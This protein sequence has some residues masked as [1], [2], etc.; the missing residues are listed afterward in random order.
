MAQHETSTCNEDVIEVVEVNGATAWY[1]NGNLHRTDGPAVDYHDGTQLWYQNGDLHREDGP[2]HIDKDGSQF[3]Y[4]HGA[5]HR[6]DG[7]AVISS[8]GSQSWYLDDK[9]VDPL[10]HFMRRKLT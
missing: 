2:A 8:N 5:I 9:E 10:V 6:E 3:W 1:R 7:P 4:K